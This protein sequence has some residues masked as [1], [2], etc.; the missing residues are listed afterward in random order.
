MP[1][2]HFYEENEPFQGLHNSKVEQDYFEFRKNAAF[3]VNLTK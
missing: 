2:E 3:P 1:L